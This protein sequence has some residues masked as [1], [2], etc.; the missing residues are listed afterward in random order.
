MG[1][2][3][4]ALLPIGAVLFSLGG[5]VAYGIL[6]I[7]RMNVYWVILSPMILAVYQIPAAGLI[8]IWKRRKA[9][10][11]AEGPDPAAKP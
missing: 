2:L 10:R 5:F 6:F 8:W 3:L 7:P 11:K 9:A 1:R 4:T